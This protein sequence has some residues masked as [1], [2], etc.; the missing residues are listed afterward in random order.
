[1]DLETFIITVFC[2]TDDFVCETFPHRLRQRGPAPVLADSEVLTIEAV[3][4]FLGLDTDQERHIYFRRHFGHLFPGLWRVHRTTFLRQA[5]NVWAVKHALWQHLVAA[6]RHDADLTLIDSLPVPVCRFAR[7]YRCRSFA[8]LANFGHDAL[9]H[10][11]YYGLRLHLGIT[12]PGGIIAATLAPANAADCAV[13]PQLLAGLTGWALGDGA[14]G[15]P[16]LRADLAADGLALLAP[17]RG[18]QAAPWPRWLVHTRRRI[19][20]VL[21]QLTE[22]YHAKRTRA[23]D[24]WHL[25]ARWLRKLVSHT[26]AVLLCQH[27]GLSPLAFAGLLTA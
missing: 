6:T 14:Y 18:A 12:W 21:S 19:E 5:A 10:Q 25:M 8:G 22:R 7:A 24:V 20:T 27:T 1:M 26:I 11:T 16:A 15:S 17:P 4:E 9:A 2:I 13:A 23:R 3:G